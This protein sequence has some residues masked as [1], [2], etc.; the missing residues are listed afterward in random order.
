[1]T[2]PFKYSTTYVLDKSHYSETYD[3]SK[4]DDS[5]QNP[6]LKAVFVALVGLVLLY[7][8]TINPYFAWFLIAIGGVEALSVRFH[9]PWWLA[10]QMISKAANAELTLSMDDEGISTTSFYVNSKILWADV[11]KIERTERGWLLF[12]KGGKSYV[13]N[14]CL[15]EEAQAYM[16][17]RAN[18]GVE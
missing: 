8:T 4:S 16:T 5:S 13:S 12:H 17:E 2:T 3:E 1:M 14:R 6:Y 18:V 15:S 9:K 10:R 7:F 11:S